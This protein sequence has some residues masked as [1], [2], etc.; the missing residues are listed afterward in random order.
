MKCVQGHDLCHLGPQENCP[1]CELEEKEIKPPR[2]S[3]QGRILF[4]RCSLGDGIG[5]GIEWI[6][7]DLDKDSSVFWIGEEEGFDSWLTDNTDLE[8]DGH[9]V[10]EGVWGSVHRDYE[11]ETDIEWD[12][13]LCRRASEEEIETGN[14]DLHSPTY[15]IE[16]NFPVAVDVD[17]KNSQAI[18]EAVS[19]ICKE[20]QKRN[21]HRVMWP[22]GAGSKMLTNP[23]M[24][25][26]EHPM[27]YNDTIL[28]ISCWERENY[29]AVC[30][31]CGL[32]YEQHKD[33]SWPSP[34]AGDCNFKPRR[35]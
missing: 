18:M 5:T 22:A 25:D 14:L 10:L 24:T 2:M 12:W 34:A 8:L 17:D 1:Y 15:K 31:T 9:Y 16:I 21:P 29:D 19:N 3:K 28:E 33:L 6:V 32:K 23:F 4:E 7:Y 11:G 35:T 20:Y 26:D 13:R 30:A 27:K